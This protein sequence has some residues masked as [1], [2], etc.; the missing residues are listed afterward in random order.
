MMCSTWP[1]R[2]VRTAWISSKGI[3]DRTARRMTQAHVRKRTD[4]LRR[5]GRIGIRLAI[6]T[7]YSK[8]DPAGRRSYPQPEGSR[9]DIVRCPVPTFF[10][11]SA[12]RMIGPLAEPEFLETLPTLPAPCRRYSTTRMLLR[13]EM[14]LAKMTRRD[15]PFSRG[16]RYN[17]LRPSRT[18]AGPDRATP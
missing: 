7:G 12:R 18:L 6:V 3:S 4:D 11:R 1:G 8:P 9:G 14:F 5:P 10:G 17:P 15:R 16:S 13:H 2:S